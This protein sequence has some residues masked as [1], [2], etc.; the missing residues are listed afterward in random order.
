MSGHVIFVVSRE[1][2]VFFQAIYGHLDEPFQ[3]PNI[4]GGGESGV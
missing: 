1:V 2:F 4:D 3:Q